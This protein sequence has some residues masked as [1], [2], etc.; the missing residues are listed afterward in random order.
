MAI[1]ICEICGKHIDGD[2]N[3]GEEWGDGLMCPACAE[4]IDIGDL[5]EKAYN[6]G[7]QHGYTL[8]IKD[9]TIEALQATR[10]NIRAGEIN[11]ANELRH[12]AEKIENLSYAQAK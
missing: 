2:H 11:A 3:P 7:K 12:C 4:N 1:Y 9:A 5:Y 10:Q 6:Q 8:A